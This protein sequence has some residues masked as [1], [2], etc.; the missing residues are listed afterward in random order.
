[1]RKTLYRVDING[2]KTHNAQPED[3]LREDF[4]NDDENYNYVMASLIVRHKNK[5]DNNCSRIIITVTR[6]IRF[7]NDYSNHNDDKK[8]T[9]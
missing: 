5:N 2:R 8:P 6:I 7:D 1:M 3:G 4:D 9:K